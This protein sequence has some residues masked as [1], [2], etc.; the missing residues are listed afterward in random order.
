[1]TLYMHGG[2][3]LPGGST[4]L[5]QADIL[6]ENDHITAVGIRN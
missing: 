2:Q 6:I 4:T 3:V 5:E 1:M